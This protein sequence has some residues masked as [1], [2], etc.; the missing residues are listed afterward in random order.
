[1]C[2]LNNVSDMDLRWRCW[3]WDRVLDWERI[4]MVYKLHRSFQPW[5]SVI[6]CLCLFI[7]VSLYVPKALC[8]IQLKILG[9][10]LTC[11]DN[12]ILRLFFICLGL[13]DFHRPPFPNRLFSCLACW[14][15]FVRLSMTRATSSAVTQL[16]QW[17]AYSCAQRCQVAYVYFRV[18]CGNKM[19]VDFFWTIRKWC[20]VRLIAEYHKARWLKEWQFRRKT[21]ASMSCYLLVIKLWPPRH[22][23]RETII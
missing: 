2:S 4:E 8:I 6:L 15:S 9:F 10:C 7:C 17:L 14:V 16:P 5:N 3:L 13:E 11:K 23:L 22:C 1:M 19:L 18:L 20:S 12:L 21:L